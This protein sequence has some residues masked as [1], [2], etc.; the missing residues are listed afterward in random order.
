MHHGDH[1]AIIKT[2]NQQDA[3]S[4]IDPCCPQSTPGQARGMAL[5]DT[6]RVQASARSEALV[7][8][9]KDKLDC[10]TSDSALLGTP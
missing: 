9:I 1:R 5:G 6:N 4:P 3:A 8:M 2:N 7:V 10:A